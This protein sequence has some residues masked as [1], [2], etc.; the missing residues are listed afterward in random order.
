VDIPRTSDAIRAD[1]GTAVEV[2]PG[3]FRIRLENPRGALMVNTYA[4]RGAGELALIDP[5]W[6]WSR[7]HL[8]TALR[9][10]G[11]G[12]LD[13]VD[14]FLYTHTH[15]DHM[16]LAAVLSAEFDRPQ[17]CWSGVAHELSAWHDF[18]DRMNDWSEWG[19]AALAGDAKERARELYAARERSRAEERLSHM[20]GP[21][22]VRNT[23]L[24]EWGDSVRVG[25][26]ELEWIDARGH[27]PFHGA[28]YERRRGWLFAGD[29]VL[30]TPTPI[31]RAMDD[32]LQL[33]RASLDRLEALDASLLLPGHGV[34]RGGDLSRAFARAR[35][36]VEHYASQVGDVL[37]SA[38]TPLG[39]Y[40]IALAMTPDSKP[41]RPS[42][43]WWVHLGLVDSHLH[44]MIA[45]GDAQM[46]ARDDG[47]YFSR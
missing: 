8:E 37:D 26:L 35:N 28:F 6:P 15:I 45:R 27:D 18:Q 36:Y 2:A 32:D 40:D 16:G 11:L 9:E 41:Y 43:R 24:L 7:E 13:D 3:L 10:L 29:A 34:Q 23:V 19:V 5:G 42:A 22:Q 30:A 46:L 31:S 4:Y 21:G 20:F 25:D 14:H 12:S 17:Y 39:L 33:Y 38:D 44:E 47:P 1:W